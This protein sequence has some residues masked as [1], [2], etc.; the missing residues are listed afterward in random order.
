[1]HDGNQHKRQYVDSSGIVTRREDSHVVKFLLPC[2]LLLSHR[3]GHVIHPLPTFRRRQW[4]AL[5]NPPTVVRVVRDMIN[6]IL[7]AMNRWW[8]DPPILPPSNRSIYTKPNQERQYSSLVFRFSRHQQ[9]DIEVPIKIGLK[10]N[11]CWCGSSTVVIVKLWRFQI[12]S[13]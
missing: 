11:R 6:E 2:S 7:S 10:L 13:N 8:L 5:V 4:T 12:D 1:M 9:N 3:S